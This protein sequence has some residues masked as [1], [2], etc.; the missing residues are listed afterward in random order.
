VVSTAPFTDMV[1][2]IPSLAE[3]HALARLLTYRNT[4]LVYLCVTKLDIFKD[5]WIYVHEKII[6][7]GRISNFRNWSPYMI[8][9]RN[10]AILALEY[11]SYDGDSIWKM[12]DVALIALA[13]QEMTQTG[14][15]QRSEISAGHVVRLHRSYP[16]YSCGYRGKMDVLQAAVDQISD[17]Y[18]IGRNGSFKYNN[19]DHS[20]LMGLLAAENIADGQHHDLWKI[21]TDYD[22]QEGAKI[23][24]EL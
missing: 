5:N 17:L 24:T 2:G 16:V 12:D 4:T 11:W 21:N 20:I 15:V 18:F 19:Q 10:E 13:T 9:G 3:V 6:K 7:T 23:K 8:R 22:Y 14:L 1:L